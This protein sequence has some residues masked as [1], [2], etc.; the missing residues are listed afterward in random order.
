LVDIEINLVGEAAWNTAL[1]ELALRVVVGVKL[2]GI[3]REIGV[4]ANRLRLVFFT[5]RPRTWDDRLQ[6][7]NLAVLEGLWGLPEIIREPAGERQLVQ[8]V[9][10]I[11][12]QIVE[13]PIRMHIRL[14]HGVVSPH[15]LLKSNDI[16]LLVGEFIGCAR[17]ARG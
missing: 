15:T 12:P 10:P 11:R 16:C 7:A 8:R 14:L 4:V 13:L 6:L 3:A 2:V 9:D 5:A 1:A 17:E